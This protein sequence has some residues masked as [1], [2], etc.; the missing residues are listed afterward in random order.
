M[1][2]NSDYAML[3]TAAHRGNKLAQQALSV[4]EDMQNCIRKSCHENHIVVPTQHGFTMLS[5]ELAGHLLSSSAWLKGV[6][7]TYGRDTRH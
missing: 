6:A 5:E 7:E 1:K 3:I 4:V 2:L